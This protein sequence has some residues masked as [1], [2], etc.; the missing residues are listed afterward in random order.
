MQQSFSTGGR[1]SSPWLGLSLDDQSMTLV[2]WCPA[3]RAQAA[4]P[5][6]AQEV[7]AQG[8]RQDLVAWDEPVRWGAA[9]QM[10]W[11]RSGMRCRR[12][13]LALPAERVV[14]QT[15]Q[16]DADL[17]AREVRAQVQWSASQTLDLAWDAVAFDYRVER[18]ADAPAE[19]PGHAVTVNWLACPL[20][21]VRAA[22]QMSR[23]ARLELQFVGVELVHG[24]AWAHLRS[25]VPGGT[26]EFSAQL[27]RA[28]EVAHQG[29]VA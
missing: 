5:R 1:R 28:C 11:Q 26:V 20:V 18:P 22:Q 8:Q 19:R 12:L 2:E 23:A 10:L 17:P 6:W 7:W 16:V 9:V 14:Q 21:L 25:E 3:P 13:A 29:A 24:A 4:G 15:L 27:H